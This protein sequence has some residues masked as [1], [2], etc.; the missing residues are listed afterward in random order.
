MKIR[1]L[2]GLLLL[3]VLSQAAD[4]I[5]FWAIGPRV[6][7]EFGGGTI[8]KTGAWG[9]GMEASY[10]KEFSE[11]LSP[12][13][14]SYGGLDFGFD[15]T[16]GRLRLY[17]EA[18]SGIAL[19]LSVGPYVDMPLTSASLRR[20]PAQLGLQGTLWGYYLVGAD[21]RFRIS[22]AGFSRS[23]GLFTK[24]PVWGAGDLF[25]GW[26]PERSPDDF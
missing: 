10:W 2:L 26:E 24:L 17:S 22:R 9:F 4:P 3:P 8:G 5:R 6:H 12:L 11:R 14:W 19:G 18:Q 13:P 1:A 16:R 7:Y 20:G 25:P 21:Y 23:M 15:I